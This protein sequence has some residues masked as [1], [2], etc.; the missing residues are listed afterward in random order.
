MRVTSVP[1]VLVTALQ[2]NSN[3][4]TRLCRIKCMPDLAVACEDLHVV[5]GALL[6]AWRVPRL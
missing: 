1:L 4:I 3:C 6:P 2:R 5:R